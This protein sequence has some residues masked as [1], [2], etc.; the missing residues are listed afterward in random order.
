M[1]RGEWTE[2]KQHSAAELHNVQPTSGFYAARGSTLSLLAQE[3]CGQSVRSGWPH[4][5]SFVVIS[6][7]YAQGLLGRGARQQQ[8]I[9]D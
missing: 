7:P 5:K 1:L 4:V 2:Q 6:T 8:S 9:N 3:M